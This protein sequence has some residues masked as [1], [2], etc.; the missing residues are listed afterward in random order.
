MNFISIDRRIYFSLMMNLFIL[1]VVVV[2]FSLASNY[3]VAVT[4]MESKLTEE[5]IVRMPTM[6]KYIALFTDEQIVSFYGI[7]RSQL[8]NIWTMYHERDSLLRH[9]RH[10]CN[11]LLYYK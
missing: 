2:I 11:L 3:V 8:I 10:I 9:P 1:F 6:A 4:V 7:S 5:V